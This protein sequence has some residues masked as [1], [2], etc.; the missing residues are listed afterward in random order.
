MKKKVIFLCLSI[1]LFTSTFAFAAKDLNIESLKRQAES[2]LSFCSN[3]HCEEDT[4]K[5]KVGSVFNPLKEA[6]HSILPPTEII[7]DDSQYVKDVLLLKQANPVV[8]EILKQ[9]DKFIT[10]KIQEKE[11]F[12]K[13]RRISNKYSEKWGSD[14]NDI[15]EQ[16]DKDINNANL[17]KLSV[18]KSDV[19]EEIS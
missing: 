12:R 15:I 11:K 6:I 16:I 9:I 2:I 17:L 10:K 4:L 5:S 14:N 1:L 8:S 3:L 18:S 13:F 19:S 7:L